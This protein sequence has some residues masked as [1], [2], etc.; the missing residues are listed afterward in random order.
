MRSLS[1]VFVAAAV[2]V[3]FLLGRRLAGSGTGLIAAFVLAV[4]PFAVKYGQEARGYALVMLLVATSLLFCRSLSSGQHQRVP[5]HTESSPRSA[6]TCI[7]S[8]RS[9]SSP[10]WCRSCCWVRRAPATDLAR[11]IAGGS[12]FFL[13]PIT[14]VL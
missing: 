2:Y 6:C 13:L 10:S 9:R 14:I 3:V 11:R 12:A 7:S 4:S 1:A 8:A 5:S